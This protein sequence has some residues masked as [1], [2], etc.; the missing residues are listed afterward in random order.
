MSNYI[1]H[2]ASGKTGTFAAKYDQ[3]A[4]RNGQTFTVLGAVDPSTYDADECGEMFTIRFADGVQIDAWPEEVQ[5]A[6]NVSNYIESSPS[7]AS[8]H[9]AYEATEEDVENVLRS[10]SLAVAN[11]NGKSFESM[12]N[13][14][15]G[16]LD[17]DLIEQAALAGDDL[18]EQTDYANDEIARQLREMGVLEPLKPAC[19]SPSPGM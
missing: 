3:H 9:T 5:S 13:E 2:P 15:H 18:D 7:R 14:L 1:D 8:G 12:A 17:F 16:K 6:M 19:D 11:T 4:E 10:N